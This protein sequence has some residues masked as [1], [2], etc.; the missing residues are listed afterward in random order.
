MNLFHG[1]LSVPE[2]VAM[3]FL[4]LNII[5]EKLN[6]KIIPHK[7]WFKLFTYLKTSVTKNY[8]CL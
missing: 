5:W 7:M 6:L 8:K 2:E 3:Y 1:K 4:S